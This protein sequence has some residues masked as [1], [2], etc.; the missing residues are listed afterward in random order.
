MDSVYECG[1]ISGL[2]DHEI[3]AGQHDA[4]E[5]GSGCPKANECTRKAGVCALTSS[6]QDRK[7]QAQDS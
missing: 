2:K 3:Q 4:R 6:R 1:P 7:V 5:Q